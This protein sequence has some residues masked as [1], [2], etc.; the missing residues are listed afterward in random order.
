MIQ[1]TFGVEASRFSMVLFTHG[2]KL[3][4][5]TIETF[6]SKSQELQELIYACY[7]RYHV[8]NNQTNDQEQT[9]QLV[10]KIITM[11]VDNG[12]GY[13][14]MKMFKKAQKASKKER[15]RHSKELRVAEQDRR[16][17]LRADVEGEMNLGGKSVKRGKCLLQ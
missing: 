15:K 2:D 3:K 7:G 4:K 14:T 1:S 12:G 13:Y 8:F 9:R 11:L 16:S 6:I 10:E 5:Q 17:T